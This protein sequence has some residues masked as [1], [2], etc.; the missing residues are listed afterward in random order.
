MSKIT[1][2]VAGFARPVVEKHGCELWDIE[3]VKE[4]GTNVLRVFIDREGGVAIAHCEAV[5]RE[6]DPLLDEYDSAI[7]GSYVFEVSSAG[8]ERRL[9]RPA[10]FERFIGSLVEIRLYKPRDGRKEYV[11][12]LRTYGDGAAEIETRDGVTRRFEKEEIAGARLRVEI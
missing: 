1:D 11:G 4:A 6:L 8:A 3:F 2:A 5:S 9:K 12:H 7:P 10:D